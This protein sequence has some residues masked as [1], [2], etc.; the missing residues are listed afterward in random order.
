MGLISIDSL[1]QRR[2]DSNSDSS[3]PNFLISFPN[4]HFHR[5]LTK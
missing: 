1:V 2:E 5:G 4:L 3:K